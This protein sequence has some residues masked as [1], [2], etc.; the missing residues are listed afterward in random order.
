MMIHDFDL[1]R[2]YLGNDEPEKLIAT[3][4]NISDKRFNKIK[5]YELASCMIRSKKGIQCIITNSR[6]CSFGYDQRVE[7]FGTKGMI[8]SENKRN[9][10]I[11]FHSNNSTSSKSPLM[12]FFVER[13][14]D[15]YKNQLYDFAKFI[16]KNIKPLALFEEGR[17]ALIMANAAKK[18]ITS[19]RIEKLNF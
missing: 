19:K 9:N 15:A 14:K 18:S 7:L 17:R 10:E 12:H 5:D 6:H 4:S 8:I 13:Y 1:A 3:G 11:S 16:K 2:F